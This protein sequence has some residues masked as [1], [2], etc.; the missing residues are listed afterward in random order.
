MTEQH[1]VDKGDELPEEIITGKSDDG[2]HAVNV[3]GGD[4]DADQRHHAGIASANFLP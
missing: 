4:G 1:D 2:R 3:S